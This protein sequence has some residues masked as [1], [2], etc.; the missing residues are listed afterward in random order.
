VTEAGAAT[1]NPAAPVATRPLIR[2]L[3]E[4]RM[5]LPFAGRVLAL[6][7]AHP[8][9]AKGIYDHS[10]GF[11]DPF[12][13]VQRT[14]EYAQRILF[15][16]DRAGTATEIRELHRDIKGTGFDGKPYHAWNRDVWTWVHLTTLEAMLY[17]LRAVRGEIP[18]DQQQ[19]LYD[20][21][22][23]VGLLYG[24][25][26]QDMPD[27]IEALHTYI[28]RGIDTKLTHRP[29]QSIV[30]LLRNLPIPAGLPIPPRLWK[31]LGHAISHPAHVLI[32]GS[33]PSTVRRRWGIRWTALHETEYQAQL[34]VLRTASAPLPDRLRMLPYAYRALHGKA[35]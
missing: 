31:A 14:A 21:V 27:D 2:E 4:W 35:S 6:Q 23:T 20:E 15:G 12:G 1:F 10:T 13:R 34:V 5:L 30:D 11:T 24:V 16:P 7:G 26:A 32:L 29:E 19:A 8:I 3:A 18:R 25:R 33:F 17:G 9:V 22:K 28:R